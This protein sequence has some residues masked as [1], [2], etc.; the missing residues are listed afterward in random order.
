MSD[1]PEHKDKV[2]ESAEK[3]SEAAGT[4]MLADAVKDLL[5][6]NRNQES[7]V[8]SQKMQD[9][10]IVG[11][12]SIDD[13]ASK[14]PDGAANPAEAK[15]AAPVTDLKGKVCKAQPEAGQIPTLESGKGKTGCDYKP[16]DPTYEEGAKHTVHISV[17]DRSGQG[18]TGSGVI[19]GSNE[20]GDRVYIATDN[21][22][23]NP[24]VAMPGVK[25]AARQV[26]MPDGKKYDAKVEIADPAHDR[27]V[28]SVDVGAGG[29]AAYK[30]ANI[31]EQP[32]EKGTGAV[33]G[34]PLN[35]KSL[36]ESPA[37]FDGT[38]SA[39]EIFGGKKNLLPG[40]DPNRRLIWMPQTHTEEG[41]SG[42]PVFNSK[43]EVVGLLEGGKNEK[44]GN[45][46]YANPLTASEVKEW[47]K[48]LSKK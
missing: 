42:G 40:E 36:Y 41:N 12:L 28:L 25:V 30:P 33:L 21:H 43:N 35:T 7:S 47:L 1:K 45:V 4:A 32:D 6:S 13:A 48:Q 2:R 11:K 16:S 14:K 29:A 8:A 26:E 5:G 37:N 39:A 44:K 24:Q 31:A 38:R 9:A 17:T 10:N 34:Y 22:V 19:I 18:G 15:P 23:A 3:P 20:K 27:A 46:S